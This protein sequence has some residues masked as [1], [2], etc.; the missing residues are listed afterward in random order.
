M[1]YSGLKADQLR[2]VLRWGATPSDLDSHLVG[3]GDDGKFHTFYSSKT[4]YSG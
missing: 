2:I 3:T 1:V 4:Y